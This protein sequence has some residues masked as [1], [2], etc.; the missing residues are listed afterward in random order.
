MGGSTEMKLPEV[1]KLMWEGERE[2]IGK[3]KK[4]MS[5]V[6][7]ITVLINISSEMGNSMFPYL[8]VDKARF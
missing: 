3:G 1:K 6:W 4:I 8:P 2:G 7:P 5:I